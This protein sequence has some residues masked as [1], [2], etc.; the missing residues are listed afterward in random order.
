ML[1]SIIRRYQIVEKPEGNELVI[2]LDPQLWS[3][4]MA[5]EL[6]SEDSNF[7][8][9]L[10]S[11]IKEKYPKVK[12]ATIKIVVGSMV[13]GTIFL[14]PNSNTPVHAQS[15]MQMMPI[16]VYVNG[17]M[18]NLTDYPFVQQQ[19]TLI[20]IRD[21][22][23]ALGAT[24]TW[25][26]ER[27]EVTV[28][29]EDNTLLLKIDSPTI[30]ANGV[31]IESE[32]SP[33]IINS[34]TYVPLR[35]V[36]EQLGA[37]VEWHQDT[38]RITIVRELAEQA[39]L[40]DHIHAYTTVDYTN[41]PTAYRALQ[42]SGSQVSSISTFAHQVQSDGTIKLPYGVN[43]QALNYAKNLGLPNYMLIHNLHSGT[44]TRDVIHSVLSNAEYVD[45]LIDEV[46]Y[47]IDYYNYD[48][49][50]VDFESVPAADR[51]NLTNFLK[52]LHD[53]LEPEGYTLMIAV[54]AKTYDNPKD[55]WNG[56]FDY[57]AIGEIVDTVMIMSYDEHW[58]GG[59]AG[60]ISS[61]PWFEKVA[62]YA[63]KTIP[64]KKVLMG[65]PLYGY[66]W[67]KNG[68]ARA[69]KQ[70][71]IE[72]VRQKYNATIQLDVKSSTPFYTYTDESGV[73]HEVWFED[74]DSIAK[75]V[76]VVNKYGFKGVGLWR[77]G[78]EEPSLWQVL[79][80]REDRQNV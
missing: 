76:E 40:L 53:K 18:L 58:S 37:Q 56:A 27:Q 68:K 39:V 25:N 66:D 41:D 48:G 50:E 80:L 75:K 32:V 23:E 14:S 34:R 5:S 52:K 22:A 77:L 69:L 45:N 73:R 38:R 78:Y 19:R 67:P 20:P 24:V 70:A 7:Y 17:K 12:I 35:I 60:P 74:N 44:F 30:I 21:I 57:K 72:N 3:V 49:V 31:A 43:L 15:V 28:E 47:Y 42:A 16:D 36:S 61:L 62:E 26:Q 63:S 65:I 71:G 9:N 51:D 1:E 59:S 11:L 79:Q 54:P 64:N 6:G 4:E 2:Y 46:L 55:N 10:L 29:L 13:V 8:K 33:Q